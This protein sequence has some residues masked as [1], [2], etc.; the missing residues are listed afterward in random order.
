M[1]AGLRE[2]GKVLKQK[3]RE[4][5]RLWNIVTETENGSRVIDG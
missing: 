3:N 5:I 4:Q 1:Q 2:I